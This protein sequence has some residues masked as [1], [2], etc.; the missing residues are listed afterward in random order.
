MKKEEELRREVS[1]IYKGS[2]AMAGDSGRSAVDKAVLR[3]ITH[4]AAQALG[5]PSL[6]E[7]LRLK[8]VLGRTIENAQKELESKPPESVVGRGSLQSTLIA[9]G[10]YF[11]E[12]QKYLRSEPSPAMVELLRRERSRD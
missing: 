5:A 4:Q 9:W 11:A 8:E 3:K 12:M 6:D 7:F 1:A 2:A 10:E